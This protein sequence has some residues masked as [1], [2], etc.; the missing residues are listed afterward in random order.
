MLR[1]AM[2]ATTLV[3]ASLAIPAIFP[4][5]ANAQIR[6]GVGVGRPYYGGY[7]YRGYGGYYGGYRPYYY[8]YPAYRNY[9]PTYRYYAPRY[10]GSYWY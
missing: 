9:Y 7:G 2:L 4:Q 6:I 8:G 3:V 5:D 1:K 10:Y